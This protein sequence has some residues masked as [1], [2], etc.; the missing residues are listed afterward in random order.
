VA[1]V[2]AIRATGIA[3]SVAIL[4]KALAAEIRAAAETRAVA[5]AAK[6]HQPRLPVRSPI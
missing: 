2:V 5:V 4:V 1:K 3:K 6:L